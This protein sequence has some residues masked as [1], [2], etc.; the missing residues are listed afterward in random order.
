MYFSPDSGSRTAQLSPASSLLV[1]R[2]ASRRSLAS[3][4]YVD[5]A[6]IEPDAMITHLVRVSPGIVIHSGMKVLPGKPIKPQREADDT[7]LGKS[8]R[9]HSIE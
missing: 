7:T 1:R 6:T 9:D 2:K 4:G 3:I 5:N 8:V